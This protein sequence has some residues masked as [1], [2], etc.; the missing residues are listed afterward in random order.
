MAKRPDDRPGSMTEVLARF[1][2]C[3]FP[4]AQSLS[5]SSGMMTLPG[6]VRDA[7]VNVASTLCAGSETNLG[8][9]SGF[10][11]P[12]PASNLEAHVSGYGLAESAGSHVGPLSTTAER[13]DHA[14]AG[15]WS[16]LALVASFGG[17][18][19]ITAIITLYLISPRDRDNRVAHDRLGTGLAN[20]AGAEPAEGEPPESDPQGAEAANM[21]SEGPARERR[22]G[23]HERP[24]RQPR[25]GSCK[26]RRP[27]LARRRVADC[28]KTARAGAG[29]PGKVSTASTP[30]YES[31][32]CFR[33]HR[34]AVT[35]VAVSRDGKLAL[36]IGADHSA[37]LWNINTGAEI[38]VAQHP[39]EILDAALL[40]DGRFA[41]TCTKGGGKKPG[42][43]RFWNMNNPTATVGF[44]SS[45]ARGAD[46]C[47]GTFS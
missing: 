31:V 12:V 14:G 38:S 25:D 37:R 13:S 40:P 47:R 22:P 33:G 27:G 35:S 39:S 17:L 15:T 20:K 29:A 41:F 9:R 43:V 7:E 24:T 2:A 34:G 18:A 30:T 36:S 46:Q 44:T 21:Q 16:R 26:L 32:P 8:E 28:E 23:T 10:A 42:A 4:S 1:E 11:N 6:P 3:V 45:R 5:A 19:A